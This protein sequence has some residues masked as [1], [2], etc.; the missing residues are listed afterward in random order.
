MTLATEVG[1]NCMTVAEDAAV[2]ALKNSAGWQAI[3][4]TTSDTDALAFIFYD[5][6]DAP[7]DGWAFTL[8]ELEAKRVAALVLSDPDSPL[9][10][11]QG[12]AEDASDKGGAVLI[13]VERLVRESEKNSNTN[14]QRWLKNKLGDVCTEMFA[15]M[16][17]NQGPRW[18]RQVKLKQAPIVNEEK[19]ETVQGYRQTAAIIVKWGAAGEEVGD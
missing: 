4:E 2:A 10:I 15:Y 9:L 19:S 6:Q 3:T 13:V 18:C 16:T 5:Q 7:T 14:Q 17:L 8:T 12:L 1:S 11:K